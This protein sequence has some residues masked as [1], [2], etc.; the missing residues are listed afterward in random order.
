MDRSV[1]VF[2]EVKDCSQRIGGESETKL[3]DKLDFEFLERVM[4]VHAFFTSCL[5]MV[6]QND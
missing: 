3:E 5:N 2:K 1:H 6:L 4:Q